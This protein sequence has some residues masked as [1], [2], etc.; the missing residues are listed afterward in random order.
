MSGHAGF[1]P[2]GNNVPSPIVNNVP[3]VDGNNDAGHVVGNVPGGE[4]PQVPD[5]APLRAADLAGQLD[6]LLFKAA[7]NVAVGTDAKGVE[8]AAKAAGLPKATVKQLMSLAEKAQKSIAK[9]DG[10]TGRQLAAAMVK[11][12]D[13]TIGWKPKDAAAK[14]LCA[15]QEAQVKLS[16]ALAAALGKASD[17]ATQ[18]ALEEIM[19]QC[20]RRVAEIETL[21]LQMAEIV[22]KGGDKVQERAD[23]LAGGKISAFTSKDALDKFDRGSALAAM[24]A[25]IK[26]LADRLAGY[27]QGLARSITEADVE[28]CTQEL[29]VL[30]AKFSDAAASGKI[31]VGGRT[32]FCDRSMLAEAAKLLSGVE[33]KIA[34]MHRDIIKGAMRNLVEKSFPFLKNEIFEARFETELSN[35]RTLDGDNAGELAHFVKL[36]NVLRN[37]A[38]AYVESPTPENKAALEN[39]AEVLRGMDR[40]GAIDCLDQSFFSRAVPGGGASAEFKEALKKFKVEVAG[41]QGKQVLKDMA[42]TV[43]RAYA[44][45]DVA[46][47]HLEELGKKLDAGPE[48]KVYVSSW[49][50]GAFRGEQT[51]SS[52][53]EARAHGYSDSDIDARIDDANVDK[54]YE[55]GSGAFN[56]VTL[57]KLK[58]GSEWVF[59]PEMPACLTTSFSSHYHGMAKNMEFTRVNLAVQQTANR[60]G[61]ND[62]MVTTKAGTHKG[63][64]GMFMEKAPGLTGKKYLKANEEKVGEGKLSMTALRTLDEAKFSKVVGRLMRQANRLMWFDILTGQGDRHSDNY[65]VEIDKETLDVSLK[66]IDNDASYGIMRTG[67]WTF[68]FPAGSMAQKTFLQTLDTV[69]VSSG[70][71]AGFMK[72]VKDDPGIKIDNKGSVEIDMGK[73][74][75]KQLVQGVFH[76]CGL[77]SAA[78]PGEIDSDLYDKLVALAADAPDGGVARAEYLDSLATR[79]G[80][81]SAQYKCAVKRL[82]DAIA[83]ARKLKADGKVYTAEQWEMHDVQKG[84]AKVALRKARNHPALPRASLQNGEAVRIRSDYIGNT[85]FFLRDFYE[86]V[87]SRGY[88]KNWFK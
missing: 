38:L 17:A 27:A 82:D 55:L 60:L 24:K 41:E 31:E 29:N 6:I 39:A 21:A 33:D 65:L 58:D 35:V 43:R 56:T 81:E 69:A 50:L 84:I 68:S 32:V 77:R 10:F 26:P 1:L 36:M 49:V 85:N 25:E 74:V 66:G 59:K 2:I 14:A 42:V 37:L 57:V 51:V 22:D 73:V 45:I 5:E 8:T 7:K 53:V 76:F 54:S 16:S 11:N 72:Q 44:G 12:E 52:I 28:S 3:A 79:L 18:S 86:M 70:N 88:H 48:N 83:H 87:T 64:F 30:K 34:S 15:A 67:L 80:A 40:S 23:A 71:K 78:V 75:N 9:L 47:A 13:G 20:D 4:G 19:L 63:R 46:V 62:V 61:L